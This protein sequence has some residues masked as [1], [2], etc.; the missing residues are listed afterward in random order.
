M[1]LCKSALGSSMN[2][3]TFFLIF[4]IKEE[5][6][7]HFAETGEIAKKGNSIFKKCKSV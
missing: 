7:W 5:K 1:Q 6:I 4:S 3:H 2:N